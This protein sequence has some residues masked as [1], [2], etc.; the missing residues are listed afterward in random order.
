MGSLIHRVGYSHDLR[1]PTTGL[2]PRRCRGEGN[3]L[4]RFAAVDW[5][6]TVE[7]HA[8]VPPGLETMVWSVHLSQ[9]LR[10][11][12][13]THVKA[14]RTSNRH[15]LHID[16]RQVTS[17]H[18]RQSQTN[19]VL[20]GFSTLSNRVEPSQIKLYVELR[21]SSLGSK[22]TIPAKLNQ[23]ARCASNPTNQLTSSSRCTN[24]FIDIH[25][26]DL[27][28]T[29]RCGHR[30]PR[31]AKRLTS[32]SRCFH[33]A[34]RYEP[35][36]RLYA[37]NKRPS[38]HQRAFAVTAHRALQAHCTSPCEK[39]IRHSPTSIERMGVDYCEV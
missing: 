22:T 39:H 3:G 13:D 7:L 14:R 35:V 16:C 5:S 33:T 31:S 21:Q 19:T 34:S 10:I 8:F 29:S 2:A 6:L 20:H 1:S 37:L 11:Q 4:K 24:R 12:S 23:R 32:T 17:H 36:R 27:T 25:Q 15:A 9:S 18:P 26:P 30:K 38:S 28:S